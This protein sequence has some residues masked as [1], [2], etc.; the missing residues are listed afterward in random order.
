MMMMTTGELY[1]AKVKPVWGPNLLWEPTGMG[2]KSC[3]GTVDIIHPGWCCCT[4][5]IYSYTLENSHGTQFSGGLVQMIFPCKWCNF[6]V[7]A[8]HFQVCSH[9][10]RPYPLQKQFTTEWWKAYS[11][12]V[13]IC[14]V[15]FSGTA[16][17]KKKTQ[18][19]IY[20]SKN[21]FNIQ[22]YPITTR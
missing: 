14:S 15:I 9:C 17:L 20:W 8:I 11:F 21:T 5:Y 19:S 3:D 18:A 12:N 22:E 13:N 6:W 1:Y 4:I 2:V 7:Q 10:V 16:P